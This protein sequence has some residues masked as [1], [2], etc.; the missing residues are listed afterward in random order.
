MSPARHSEFST[1]VELLQF[2]E[3]LRKLSGGKPTGFKLCIGHPWEWFAICKAMLETGM[4]PDFIVVDGA[5]GG[6]GAAPLEFVDHVGTPLQEGLLL[7]HNTL[8]GVNLRDTRAHRLQRQD[9]QR[10][11]H[12]AR[13]GARRGLVQLGARLHVCARLPAG[14]EM[15][16]RQLAPRAS[17]RRTPCGNARSRCRTRSS[18]SISFHHHTMEALL[19]IAQAAG[20]HHPN[21]FRA[22]HLVRR[23]ADNDVRLLS[24]VLLQVP[25]GFLL[26]GGRPSEVAASSVRRVLAAGGCAQL[27]AGLRRRGLSCSRC[28]S[29]RTRI[30]I[31]CSWAASTRPAPAARIRL[32]MH[33]GPRCVARLPPP[34]NV[35]LQPST[36]EAAASWPRT[37]RG[38]AIRAAPP[39]VMGA[40]NTDLVQHRERTLPQGDPAPVETKLPWYVCAC[41]LTSACAQAARRIAS[42][43]RA[44]R[45]RCRT[46]RSYR[47]SRCARAA[48]QAD[49]VVDERAP[50]AACRRRRARA[51]RRRTFG[52]VDDDEVGRQAQGLEHRQIASRSHG[53]PAGLKPVDTAEEL[54]QPLDELQQLDEAC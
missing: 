54:A 12:R 11:R 37:A 49:G 19:E 50:S 32:R 46:A 31:D 26:E 45:A 4:A 40:T 3:R 10:V 53:W 28:R 25:P 51:A 43:R 44:S 24:N 14:A 39:A 27:C 2:V 9:H 18:A 42:P 8:V 35:A 6:T 17:R 23:V 30:G 1:P 38:A 13:D 7:V 21:E 48:G 20:L 36:F 41:G 22:A 34:R 52:A 47:C 5:E 33:G 15:P 16:H 29:S